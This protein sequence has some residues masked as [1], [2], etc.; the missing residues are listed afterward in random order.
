MERKIWSTY[1]FIGGLIGEGK[2]RMKASKAKNRPDAE[3]ADECHYNTRW[4]LLQCLQE[5][6]IVV[7]N[8]CFKEKYQGWHVIYNSNENFLNSLLK[9]LQKKCHSNNFSNV[10]INVHL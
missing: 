2:I 7:I 3:E 6:I 9:I 10:L 8:Y 5:L 1:V 4:A